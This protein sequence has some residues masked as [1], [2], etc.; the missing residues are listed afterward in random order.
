MRRKISGFLFILGLMTASCGGSD[1]ERFI[2]KNKEV[3]RVEGCHL[4]MDSWNA[5][6]DRG[7]RWAGLEFVCDVPESAQNE[8]EWWGDKPH[9]LAFTMGVGECLVLGKKFYC[10]EKIEPGE[11]TFKAT[12]EWVTRHHDHIKPLP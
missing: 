9:P 8:K 12:Y 3:A 1:P 7:R 4:F 2:L 6:D 11:A 5:A 10:L